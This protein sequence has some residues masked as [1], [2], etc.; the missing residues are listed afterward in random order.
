MKNRSKN[1]EIVFTLSQSISI[2]FSCQ[3]YPK[4]K[5]IEKVREIEL[6]QLFLWVQWAEQEQ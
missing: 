3:V 5:D 2:S 1:Q 4:I 6:L